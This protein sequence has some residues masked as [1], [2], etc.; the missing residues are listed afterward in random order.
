MQT[1]SSNIGPQAIWI[2]RSTSERQRSFVSASRA[3]SDHILFI[4]K[5]KPFRVGH[6]C[7]CASGLPAAHFA[8]GG[9]FS[10][11]QTLSKISSISL[12]DLLCP[13]KTTIST[14]LDH[15]VLVYPRVSRL[16]GKRV[17]ITPKAFETLSFVSRHTPGGVKAVTGCRR[18]CQVAPPTPWASVIFY[19][20]HTQSTHPV[21][22][23][24][25]CTK[26]STSRIARFR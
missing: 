22:T 23:V 5:F 1:H 18:F 26:Y 6:L 21:Y 3:R 8:T 13:I 25:T 10:L 7:S 17:Q 14:N 9:K 20:A 24:E 12:F 2:F 15:F 19:P 4:S 11:V 16:R